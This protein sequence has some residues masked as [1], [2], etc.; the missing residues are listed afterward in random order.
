MSESTASS[1]PAGRLLSVD[2][3]RGF[4]MF[5]IVGAGTLV[6]ALE[7]MKGNPV[8]NFLATQLSHAQWTGFRFYDLIFPLF[9]FLVGVSIVFSLDKALAGGGR[10]AV[11]ARVFRRAIL[12]FV[13]GILYYGGLSKPWPDVQLGGVLHRIAACYLFAA[14]VYTWI[15][16]TRGLLIVAAVL[17]AGY[18][19]LLA[20]VPFPDLKLEKDV[21]EAVAARAVSDSP[22][23]IAA[24]TEG[25]VSG[26]YEEGRNL[27]NFLDFLLLPGKKA[28]RYYINEGLLS[29]L[30]A[31]ALSLFGI[32]AGRL[33]KDEETAPVRKCL[34][35]LGAGGGALLLGLLWSLQFPVIKRI[36]T[37]S[38]ILVAGGLSAWMLALFYYLVEVRRW[39]RWCRPFVWIGGNALTV[40]MVSRIV[41]F[42]EIAAWFTGGD[43]GAFLDRHVA[44]GFGAV[45]TAAVALLLVFLFAR[46]L[47]RRGI[48]IRV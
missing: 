3:L 6:K 40:Y 4:D 7:Q 1:P 9:L 28:Q 16:G 12:L 47:H 39:R 11:L 37:S 18:G 43:I 8:T 41:S 26:L 30:P 20:F 33:L 23:A 21:V 34:I 10:G 2:A 19:A 31:I 27:T 5:W 13:L 22:F 35:L 29:T 32:L 48:F 24:A 44:Q 15:R 45:V 38:F 46:F 42:R 36:W 25:R 14:L 17:L